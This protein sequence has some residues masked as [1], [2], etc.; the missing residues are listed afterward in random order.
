MLERTWMR[1]SNSRSDNLKSKACPAFDK[2]RPRACRGEPR[3]RIENPKWVGLL[4]LVLTFK[5]CGTVVHAQ[6]N[7]FQ[8]KSIRVIRGGQPGDL[9]DLWT[10]H[11]AHLFGKTYSRQSERHRAEHAGRRL[12]DRGELCLQRR[13]AGRAD[14]GLAQFGHL[15]GSTD[16][17]QGSA[18]STGRS[19]I[20]S[21]RRSRPSLLFIIRGD[22]PYKTIDD[23]RKATEP[24]K[25]GSTGTASMT[26]HI[27]KLI[28]EIFAVPSLSSSPDIKG[29]RTST[30][31]SNA[32]SCSAG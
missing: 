29:P 16:R 24:P 13:Q 27:P 23:L 30:L 3:R 6:E 15:H 7:F 26:Y 32:A 19:L 14:P 8:G 18:V 17:P 22:S 25:C 11:I 1:S 4:A 10:R 2:L 9:Y 21:V 5:L 12:G 28:E 20:G 31:R